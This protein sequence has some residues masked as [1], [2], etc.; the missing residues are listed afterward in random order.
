MARN[1][2]Y[3]DDNA[4]ML[5]RV[6]RIIQLRA[7]RPD[8]RSLQI[9]HHLFHKIGCDDF[10]IVI[11]KQEILSLCLF[12]AEIIDRRI[13]KALFWILQDTDAL[14]FEFFVIGKRCFLSAVVLNNQNLIGWIHAL[15]LN[16]FQT[17]A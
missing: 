9:G 6:V 16:G 1:A 12:D 5:H 2:A 14:C 4:G 15:L 3:P 7:D 11:E 10:H 13:V 17:G 8:L